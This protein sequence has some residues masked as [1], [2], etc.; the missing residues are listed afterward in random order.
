MMQEKRDGRR[1][2]LTAQLRIENMND[3]SGGA[4]EIKIDVLD[5][6]KTGVGFI[7]NTPLSIGAVYKT[8]LKLWTD[9]VIH[10]FLKIVR[11]EQTEDEQY[12]CGTI[13]IGLSELDAKRIEVYDLVN[14]TEKEEA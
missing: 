4:E 10:A 3:A 1:M 5:V 9:E 7:C 6:S 8:D 13:F 12:I 14:H 2:S 11:I